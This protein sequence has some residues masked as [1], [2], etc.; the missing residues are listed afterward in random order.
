[1]FFI[2]LPELQVIP[3]IKIIRLEGIHAKVLQFRHSSRN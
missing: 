2:V 3:I 1:M